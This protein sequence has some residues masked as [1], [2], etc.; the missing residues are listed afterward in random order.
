MNCIGSRKKKSS[1]PF[2]VRLDNQHLHIISFQVPYPPDYGG[3]IDVYYKIAALHQAGIRIHLHCYQYD[4][5][6]AEALA[7]LCEEVHYYP[8][9]A[10]WKYLFARTPFIVA[11]RNA[12][13]LVK[14]IQADEHPVL[15]EGLHTTASLKKLHASGRTCIV[16]MHNNEPQYYADLARREQRL[17]SRL[18]FQEESRRLT[19][20]E[21]V[22]EHADAICCISPAETSHYA[23]AFDHVV[24]IPAFHGHQE[25]SS[26]TG[27]GT[28][29]LYHGNLRVN[30]N[31]EAVLWI[32]QHICPYISTE[33]RI[34]GAQP[35]PRIYE[36][37][38]HLSHVRIIPDPT[39]VEL[40]ALI[41]DAH[42]HL[43]PTFQETGMKLKLLNALYNGRFCL[44]TKQMIEET[45]IEPYCLIMH[46]A[47]DA[48]VAI[49][50]YMQIPFTEE[51]KQFRASIHQ[52]YNDARSAAMLTTLI[53]AQAAR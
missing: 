53:A 24:H 31:V 38:R 8:R 20:Y 15:F 36:A 22:L 5:P 12:A 1:S 52:L 16:R 13:A 32:L 35:D 27:F 21:K 44:V 51:D 9:S 29:I 4:R 50:S 47:D 28:Y 6:V 18:Y 2:I 10:M 42:I 33:V 34:A 23:A 41:Q 25:V 45:G 49:R 39:H 7:S 43:L 17:F 14:R 48:I 3:V 11:T 30:E 40:Q 19:T 46:N 26:K 37:A